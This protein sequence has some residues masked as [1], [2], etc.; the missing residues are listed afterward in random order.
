MQ[1]A[2][3]LGQQSGLPFYVVDS[4]G[5]HGHTFGER[6]HQAMASFFDLGFAKVLVIGNDCAELQATDINQAAAL[7]QN[8]AAVFGPA[9]DGG[10]YLLGLDKTVFTQKRGFTHINWQTASVLT[11]LQVWC[12]D[13]E[14]I[15]LSPVY[16][17]LDS[18]QDLR[19]AF[20]KKL[21]P[22][23]L[24][25]VVAAIF[26]TIQY[27]YLS[28]IFLVISQFTTSFSFRGPPLSR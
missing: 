5:Q 26:A 12:G 4:N 17:D 1:H 16:A 3:C 9:R 6:L 27:D 13:Q 10:V 8:K 20:F 23:P 15:T 28:F 14:T 19:Y 24:L 22:A 18:I 25:A 7:L 11:E 2:R 21:L